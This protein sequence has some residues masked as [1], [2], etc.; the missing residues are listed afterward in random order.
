M[1]NRE[2]YPKHLINRVLTRGV[3][4][5]PSKAYVFR[6]GLITCPV[7]LDQGAVALKALG[8]IAA[9]AINIRPKEGYHGHVVG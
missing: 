8:G 2:A 7:P 5:F 3:T 9:Y 4:L 1:S 6:S